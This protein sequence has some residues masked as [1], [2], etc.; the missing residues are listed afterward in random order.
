MASS[1]R[2]TIGGLQRKSKP[3][4]KVPGGFRPPAPTPAMQQPGR[5]T[6]M[7]VPGSAG[8]PADDY[9]KRLK[10]AANNGS[11]NKNK[12]KNNA[13][14]AQRQAKLIDSLKNSNGKV[15]SKQK[16]RFKIAAASRAAKLKIK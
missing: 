14:R 16:A 9:R 3:K 5:A 11:V 6:I 13:A 10:I 1:M 4:L 7:P 15:N 8:A 2:R 12:A